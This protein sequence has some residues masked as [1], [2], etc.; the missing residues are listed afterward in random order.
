[1]RK[2]IGICVF[3]GR[4]RQLTEDHIPPKSLFAKGTAL[5]KVCACNE[6][7]QESSKDDEFLK[8]LLT[9]PLGASQL[10][11]IKP[12]VPSVIRSFG[13]KEARRY[14]RGILDSIVP[15]EITTPGGIFLG[16]LPGLPVN[17]NRI[18]R[19][20]RKIV[21]GLFYEEMKYALP[22]GYGVAVV[23]FHPMKTGLSGGQFA[24]L[25]NVVAPM[26]KSTVR[27][28]GNG[29]FKY[30]FGCSPESRYQTAWELVLGDLLAAFALTDK[31]GSLPLGK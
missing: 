14:A 9:L 13:K 20:I 27:D 23:P 29:M 21:R 26:I 15:V 31:L 24:K 28:I 11:Q 25:G 18:E 19:I 6:C 8:L 30:R 3:C 1:M 16:H 4:R 7:N 2:K 17:R 12:L 22:R 5:I 10:P